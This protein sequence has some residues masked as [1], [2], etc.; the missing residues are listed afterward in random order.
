MAALIDTAVLQYEDDIDHQPSGGVTDPTARTPASRF[1]ALPK[2]PVPTP[3]PPVGARAGAGVRARARAWTG[4]LLARRIQKRGID[5]SSLTFIPER[6]KVPLQRDGIDPVPRLAQLREHDPVHRLKL[7]FAFSVYLVTGAEHVKAVLA[8]RDSWSNDIRHLL[9]GPGPSGADEVGGL[10]FTD[11]PLHTRL[12]KIITPE[13]TMRR[14]ARLEPMIETIVAQRLDALAA[15]GAPADLAKLVSFPVPFQTICALL[16]LELDDRDAF[17]RLG[18]QRFDAT[19]GAAAAFGAVSAQREFLFDAVARQRAEPGPGLIGQIIRDEGDR[20]SD[21]D[22]A[23]LADGVFTGGYE[24]TAGMISLSTMVLLRDPAHAALVRDGSRADVD[25]V[26]EE[27]LRHLSVVQMAFPR[28]AKHDLDLFGVPLKA[29]D[30]VLASLSGANR[31]PRSAGDQPEVFDP[32][33][34]P[35]SGH[36]AF[37]HG[38]HRCIGAE[39][40]RMELRVVLPALFRRFPDLALAVPQRELSFRE[41]SFVY[42]LD[43]LPVRF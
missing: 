12:R 17:A 3:R 11:P 22:L 16:G 18:V 24:T 10:G 34:R 31:D 41:L 37:G 23:G 8:D 13:F 39:L 28:F 14:L 33:R 43:E 19:A 27:L 40:A 38:I 26:V 35:N 29:G 2:Y 20:I 1:T 9:P 32:L 5:L 36:L 7:P 21:V 15:A 30:V 6:T 4:K 42:G 25:R